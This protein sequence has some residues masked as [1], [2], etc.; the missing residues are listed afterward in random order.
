MENNDDS[1]IRALFKSEMTYR[2]KLLEKY[3]KVLERSEARVDNINHMIAD[4][5]QLSRSCSERL[6]KEQENNSKLIEI[7]E[8]RNKRI[9]YLEKQFNMLLDKYI[10]NNAKLNTNTFNL[11]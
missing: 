5:L 1:D 9:E 3:T 8:E 4:L 11:K 2:G 7:I 10:L 6:C